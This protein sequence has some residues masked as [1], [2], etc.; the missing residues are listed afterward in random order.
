MTEPA[1]T[2]PRIADLI[3]EPIVQMMMARDGVDPR[4]L[5][6]LMDRARVSVLAARWRGA[7]LH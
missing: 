1:M 7:P 4:D 3:A 5:Q 2:T 6:E